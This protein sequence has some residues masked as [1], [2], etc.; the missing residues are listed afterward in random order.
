MM[1][2]ILGHSPIVS[3][4]WTTFLCSQTITWNMNSLLREYGL[5]VRPD[6]CTFAAPTEHFLGHR[7]SSDGIRTLQS[8]VEAIQYYPVPTTIKELHAI[9][10][11]FN[12]YHRFIPIASDHMASLYTILSGNPK[13]LSW[14]TE[15]QSAFTNTKC[16]LSEVATLS[17][18]SQ[19]PHSCSLPTPAITLSEQY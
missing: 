16:I 13:N 3:Y 19:A 12:Y 10:G 11:M 6:K 9:L 4:I 1:N 8:K 7:I 18:S 5:I 15:Q 2:S 17:S 14:S